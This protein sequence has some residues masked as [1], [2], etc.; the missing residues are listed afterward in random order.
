MEYNKF[1]Y[2]INKYKSY[3]R[4]P[5]KERKEH[6]QKKIDFYYNKIDE[7]VTNIK[8]HKG[9]AFTDA[10]LMKFLKPTTDKLSEHLDKTANIPVFQQEQKKY[11]ENHIKINDF[12]NE[13]IEA[14]DLLNKL[15]ADTDDKHKKE[16]QDK[17][18]QIKDKV[19]E[20]KKLSLGDIKKNYNLKF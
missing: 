16:I 2:K 7:I 12:L 17:L 14:N 13:L 1:I 11:K 8:N 9:G 6:Y 20:Q 15:N 18:K 4:D 10:D 5:N 19:D 3:L